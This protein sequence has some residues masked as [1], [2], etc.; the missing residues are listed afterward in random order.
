MCFDHSFPLPVGLYWSEYGAYCTFVSGPGG[1]NV[2]A[3]IL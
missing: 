2:D 1:N 3:L